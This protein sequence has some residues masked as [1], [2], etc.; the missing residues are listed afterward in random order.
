MAKKKQTKKKTSTPARSSTDGVET[1]TEAAHS[2]SK[3]S[4]ESECVIV[5]VGASAGGLEA[6]KAMVDAMPDSPGLALVVIQHLDPTKP[7]LTAELLA[8]HTKMPV[9]QV[10]KETLVEVNH[11]YVIPPNK[12]LGIRGG[13]LQ[14]NEPQQRR[15]A[16][17][18]ID[19]FLRSLADDQRE[20][21]AAVILSGTGT[22]GTLGA[23]A[24]KTSGG[25]V[26]AQQPQSAAHAGMP[27]SVIETGIVDQVLPPE[28]IP[29]ALIAY[30][31]HEFI[32]APQEES[33]L[34][35]Q[36]RSDLGAI[37][38]LIRTRSNLD[39]RC[40]KESTLLRRTRRRMG[41]LNINALL[42]YRDH[43]SEHDEEVRALTKD[44]LISVTDFFRDADAW[45]TLEKQAIAPLVQ[46]KS[47][48]EPYRAWI[49]GC[50]TGE[51]AF[52]AAMLID[53][54]LQ[55]SQKNC[56][57]QIF[58]SDVDKDA[59]DHAR[60]ARYPLSI[61]ADVSAAR[62]S[63]F[64][65]EVQGNHHYQIKKNIREAVV[66]AEQNL[67]GDPP[68][69]NLD[70]IC[71]RNLLIYLKPEVQQKLIALFH[72]AL[73]EGGMLFLGNAETIGPHADLFDIV[74]KKWRIYRRLGATRHDIVDF[75]VTGHAARREVEVIQPPKR[76]DLR[77]AQ[78]AQQRLIDWI[79]PR[80]VLIDRRWQI[81][82]YSGDTDAYLTHAPGSPTQ[83]V[84]AKCRQGL[85]TKLRAAV[86]KALD[87]GETITVNTRVTRDGEFQAV[88]VT[89][90]PVRDGEN[91]ETLVLIL[92]DEASV[93]RRS[94]DPAEQSEGASNPK[95]RR[96]TGVKP[97]DEEA[98]EDPSLT[99]GVTKETDIDNDEMVRQ[100]EEELAETKEEL[101]TTIEQLEA[102]NEE[103]K[104]SSEE[105]M[106]VNEELQSTN[107]ELETS[108]EELQS[109]NEELNTVNSQ[110]A[111]KVEQLEASNNDLGNL[112]RSTEIATICLD[113]ELRIKWFTPVTTELMN[114]VES[115]VGRP[116]ADFSHKLANE[117]LMAEAQLVLDRLAPIEGEVAVQAS[118]PVASEEAARLLPSSRAAS[119]GCRAVNRRSVADSTAS[120]GH[121]TRTYLR[122]I[123]P[124]RT[125]DN[126][127]A[128]VV[129][130]LVDITEQKR[131]QV[132]F[133]AKELADKI[134]D[135]VREP[136]LVLD[137]NLQVVSANETFYQRF[138]ARDAETIGQPVYA[139]DD[140]QWDIP[141]LREL[142]ENVLP[143]NHSFSDFEVEHEF[144]QLGRRVMMLNA[145]RID[146]H[147]LIL[148]AIED[149]TALRE[150]E[151]QN[152]QRVAMLDLV[153]DVADASNKAQSVDDAMR[154]ALGRV[155]KYNHWHVGHAWRLADDDSRQM[156]SS[157]IWHVNDSWQAGYKSTDSHDTSP[158][159][160]QGKDDS[161]K[162]RQAASSR[163]RNLD[164]FRRVTAAAR[165]SPGEGLV[166]R[167]V[168][169]GQAQWIE[170][171]A[172]F[173]DWQRGDAE[174]IGLYAA[175]AFPI[176]VN[177]DVVAV[178]EFFSD[179]PMVREERFMEFMP[180]VGVHLSQ[181]IERKRL[182]KM[183]AD[184]TAALQRHFGRELHDSVSQELAGISMLAETLRQKLSEAS[185]PLV[186]DAQL[187]VEHLRAAGN[188]VTRLSHGLL[189]VDVDGEGLMTALEELVEHCD[190]MHEPECLFRCRERVSVENN[191]T[192]THMYRIAQEALQNAT[193]HGRPK[194]IVVQFSKEKGAVVLSIRDDGIGLPP[195]QTLR[196]TGLR[197]MQYRANLIGAQLKIDSQPG[198][199]VAITCRLAESAIT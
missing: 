5:G 26:I 178:I 17:V 115:D 84:L 44:L 184:A 130:T 167:V 79:A 164:E 155:C 152:V 33:A 40:Y 7:S 121:R 51:E 170:D 28:K 29:G 97:S 4:G 18:P 186:D 132:L 60:Q 129:I 41:L 188:Q 182:E 107:E 24:V 65:V 187:V 148:L 151:R 163:S 12:S 11:I 61:A 136:M 177:S 128:G 168:Q 159:R 145:R 49:P 96:V 174:Q 156:V 198:K 67:V 76:R 19:Y 141:R 53:E 99:H 36:T 55:E 69:S 137:P 176:S 105:V 30:A 38:A 112:I 58:A 138:H 120:E 42:E 196:G 52:S 59:L 109:L 169:T 73:R 143:E 2:H 8:K 92:F 47:L 14:L 171:V 117:N 27:Q 90:R 160:K 25:L 166:G 191:D 70:L 86:Q 180:S 54:Q 157:G 126:R 181:V 124:Y 95:P 48:E 64:F 68:F 56:P 134:I 100:L 43:L 125:E 78:L 83:D 85:R 116:L 9:G 183:I 74:S 94:Y 146:R 140:G 93:P 32:R 72:F 192:A 1:K 23:K 106:S 88:R 80:A 123:V 102:S 111:N 139:L 193:K 149:V 87:Q 135:T 194:T 104:A 62:L 91:D 122:R 13:K 162:E 150:S 161:L 3:L 22:D 35:D 98:A 108:K 119:R 75:P 142:L 89:A 50:A 173:A 175:T 20:R 82:Y 39:L 189:P 190:Q 63:R 133:E 6:L 153:H 81:L 172:Q 165:V 144:A 110:L 127:I 185:S 114:I 77:L 10:E 131:A 57:M 45:R 34:A 197:I 103:F 66:F 158:K 113:Q 31:R 101:Q 118:G 147:Q 21:A 37:L 199:G 195:R 16:R 154:A 46:R 179:R 15:G 71:C